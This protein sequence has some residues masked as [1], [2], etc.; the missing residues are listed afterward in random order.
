MRLAAF[1]DAD[2]M[3]HAGLVTGAAVVAFGPGVTV[4]DVLLDPAGHRANGASFA[5]D[6]VTLLAPYRP[7]L[8]VGVGLN[9]RRHAA[10]GGSEVPHMPLLFLKGPGSVTAPGGP[11]LRPEGVCQLDYEG[12]L[13]FVIGADGGVGGWAVADDVSARDFRE[14][15]LVRQKAGDTFCPWGPWVTTADEVTDPY[16]LR[17]R[18]WVNDE[19]RQDAMT[20]EL[21]FRADEI[22][23][24]LHQTIRTQP[25][26]LI[27]TGT[28]SGVG[29]LM[30]PPGLL[31]PGDR[32]RI[33]I[34]GLGAIEHMIVSAAA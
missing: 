16:G 14:T 9:Y 32:V 19:L 1:T 34:D 29:L 17:L 28:P 12:E 5:L 25:G 31:E 7:R 11:V 15:T 21:I 22:L 6:A 10:E 30:D 24:T 3:T 13:A 23:A 20:S 8:V 18:T 27:L 2:G 4:L 26:D 33:E